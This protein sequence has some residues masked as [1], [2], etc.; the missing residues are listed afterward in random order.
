MISPALQHPPYCL[1]HN[2]FLVGV[3][4]RTDYMRI[5][6]C[7]FGEKIVLFFLFIVL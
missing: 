3:V 7:F 2:L 4:G 6:I 1:R 5:G